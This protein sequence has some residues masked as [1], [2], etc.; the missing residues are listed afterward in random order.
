MKLTSAQRSVA[1]TALVVMLLV[2]LPAHAYLDPASG[3]IFLQL[4]L[5]GVAGVALFFKLTWH[6]I[7][8]VLRR[9]PRQKPS[10]PSAE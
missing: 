8:G 1:V 10:E 6:K 5:G 9:E 7:R 4:L 3:S 2:A